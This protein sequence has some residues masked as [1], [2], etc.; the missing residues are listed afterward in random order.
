MCH[1]TLAMTSLATDMGMGT[2][3]KNASQALQLLW[4]SGLPEMNFLNFIN[5]PEWEVS[6]GGAKRIL[7]LWY[8]QA[9]GN[10]LYLPVWCFFPFSQGTLLDNKA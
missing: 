1:V 5:I 2:K 8:K 9:H 6:G 10:K 3:N 7:S 4:V